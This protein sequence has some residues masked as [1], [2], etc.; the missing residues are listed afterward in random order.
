MGNQIPICIR[1]QHI[2]KF[3]WWG[4]N[5]STSDNSDPLNSRRDIP[6]N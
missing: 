1:G 6:R 4:H 3:Q 5:I 2:L